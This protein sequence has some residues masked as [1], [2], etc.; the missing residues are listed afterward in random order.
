MPLGRRPQL[1]Q[2]IGGFAAQVNR[3]GVS[4]VVSW[5]SGNPVDV[6]IVGRQASGDV[7]SLGKRGGVPIETGPGALGDMNYTPAEQARR[8]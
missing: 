2:I 1:G 6:S 4:R 5:Q 3:R 8:A 7:A